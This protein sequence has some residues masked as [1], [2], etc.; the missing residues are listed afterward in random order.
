MGKS[1]PP[2][3]VLATL[4]RDPENEPIVA[5]FAKRTYAWKPD[6][7]LRYAD[8][9]VPLVIK[10]VVERLDDRPCE[11]MLAELDTYPIKVATDVVVV[12]KVR[13]ERDRPVAEMS[14][15]IKVG[16]HGKVV[17]V[18]GDRRVSHERGRRPVFSAPKPFTEM[19]LTYRRAYGG[20]DSSLTGKEPENLLEMIRAVTP[21]DRPGAYPR[22]PA[23]VGY[24]VADDPRAVDGL[25]LPNFEDPAASLSPERLI[26]GDPARWWTM[27]LPFGLSWFHGGWY[28]RSAWFGLVPRFTP[29][30][31]D[32]QVEE[33]RRG[34]TAKGRA[35]FL[36]S[37]PVEQWIDWRAFNG[38]SPGLAVPFLNGN[39][40]VRLVGLSPAGE[41]RFA[42]SGERPDVSLRFVGKALAPKLFLHTLLFEPEEGRFCV[43]WCARART[44]R[45]LPDRLPT[46]ADPMYDMLEGFEIFVDGVALP[47]QREP[48]KPVS[49]F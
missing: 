46:N 19:P 16:N 31:D 8:E 34:W 23:G 20:I 9:Q 49:P 45:F 35:R 2:Y 36:A 26:V 42:L 10:E 6:G 38:A 12:G 24:V 48:Y 14:A 43:V 11:A 33:V 39:E 4:A 15:G 17:R 13:S 32:D 3:A 18:I 28:P 30:D 21:E 29:P 1:G 41:I 25:S 37:A 7:T 5:A 22:N 27:P 40:D 44:P 47:H